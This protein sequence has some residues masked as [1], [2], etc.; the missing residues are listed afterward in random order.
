MTIK[1]SPF[2]IGLIGFHLL[3]LIIKIF[4][5]DFFLMDSYEYYELAKNILTNFEF[6]SRDLNDAIDYRHYTKRPPLYSIFI[7]ISSL[8]LKTKIGILL[9]QNLISICSI[10]LIKKVFEENNFKINNGLFFFFIITSI[11]QFIYS[12]LIMS[13][14]FFQFIIVLLI[15]RLHQCLKTPSWKNVLWYQIVIILLFLTKPVFYLFIVPNIFI[16]YL[17]YKKTKIRFSP[18]SAILPI[19]IFILYVSWNF[20]RTGSSDFSS[21]QNINLLEWNLKYFHENKFGAEK[22]RTI[23]NQI[24]QDAIAI[25]SYKKQQDFIKREVISYLKDDIVGYGIFHAK[26]CVRIFID[27][28]RFDLFNFFKMHSENPEV[29]LLHHINNKGVRGAITFLKNQPIP[30]LFILSIILIFNLL[31]GVGFIWFWIKNYRETSFILATIL[32]IILY[33]VALT[34]PL[35]ASRFFVPILPS[36]L[37]ISVLGFSNLTTS[38]KSY[39]TEKKR[40]KLLN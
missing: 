36:Y 15:Y 3:F 32:F 20:K 30:L 1:I 33:I 6:Y 10:L 25:N 35:G 18:F 5:G 17:L 27:P 16:T 34:G 28:G 11:N 29:G 19:L 13:E 4:I 2:T 12:N 39:Y 14:I 23:S 9:C 40:K 26:G 21:I 31:K 7:I 8:F 22:A 24:K 37:I 38:L